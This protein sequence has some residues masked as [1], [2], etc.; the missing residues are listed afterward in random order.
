MDV[1]TFKRHFPTFAQSDQNFVQAKLIAAASYMGVGSGC[2]RWPSF[3][4]AG[5]PLTKSDLA[6]GWLAAHYLWTDPAGTELRLTGGEG[7]TSYFEEFENIAR[8]V[9]MGPVVSGG[10]PRGPCAPPASPPNTLAF[11][12]GVG[13]ASV[14]NGSTAVGFSQPQTLPAGTLIVFGSQAGGYYAIAVSIVSATSAVLMSPYT[15]VTN[16]ATSWTHT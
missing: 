15:G 5:Q 12:P 2:S 11:T 14:T 13:T 3:A 1:A 8:V 4:T 9:G 6:Q 16:A 7:G 10:R